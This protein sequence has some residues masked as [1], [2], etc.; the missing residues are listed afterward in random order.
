[1]STNSLITKQYN[2]FSGADITSSF[3]IQQADGTYS[4][5]AFGEISTISYSLFTPTKPVRALGYRAPKA[6][7]TGARLIAGS[8]VFI[9]FD[10]HMIY[11]LWNNAFEDRTLI[12]E[13]P[14]FDVTVSFSNEYGDQ[15]SLR[16]YGL[17]LLEE[18]QTMS[19]SDI[20]TEQT[21]RFMAQDIAYLNPLNTGSG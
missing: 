20:Y 17:R 12:D 18:G 10:H 16:L 21:F 2:S 9:I 11:D 6:Y 5:V 1:M 7:T 13:L 4:H 19:V 15:S 14:P 3:N 8:L